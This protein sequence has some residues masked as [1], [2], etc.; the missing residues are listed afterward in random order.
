[1]Y[2]PAGERFDPNALVTRSEGERWTHD[3]ELA[4]YLALAPDVVLAE[5][6]RHLDPD[7][8]TSV[9]RLDLTQLQ[10][11]DLRRP[12]VAEALSLPTDPGWPLDR[13]RARAV[14]SM[15]RRGLPVEALIVPSVAFLD[16]PDRANLVIWL[17]DRADARRRI[18]RS[19][20]IGRWAWAAAEA[21]GR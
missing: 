17:D 5:W 3:G 13:G 14:A 8:P 12:A 20:P 18:R 15:V 4:W 2:V 9:W 19:R 10:A 11:L 1:V 6:A 7:G 21:D 16:R